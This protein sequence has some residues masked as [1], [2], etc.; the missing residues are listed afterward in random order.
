MSLFYREFPVRESFRMFDSYCCDILL[1]AP[2]VDLCVLHEAHIPLY[3]DSPT[4]P[5]VAA[6]IKLMWLIAEDGWPAA[7]SGPEMRL[8]LAAG[9]AP[10][11]GKI[12]ERYAKG[13]Y[14][15][16]SDFYNFRGIGMTKNEQQHRTFEQASL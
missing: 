2:R 13:G 8:K 3:N 15:R 4:Q 6:R 1:E 11:F 7:A 10:A 16:V 9:G 5:N 14:Q 12:C